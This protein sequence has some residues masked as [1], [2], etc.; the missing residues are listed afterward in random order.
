[1]TDLMFLMSKQIE[2]SITNNP[3]KKNRVWRLVLRSNSCV[4]FLLLVKGVVPGMDQ[5]GV[6][7]LLLDV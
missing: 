3:L 4:S 2:C 1:M 5:G 6:S 7:W